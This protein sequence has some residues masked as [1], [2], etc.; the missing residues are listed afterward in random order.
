MIMNQSEER[1]Q[2]GQEGEAVPSRSTGLLLLCVLPSVPLIPWV[3]HSTPR[4]SSS[5][6]SCPWPH[7]NSIQ[8]VLEWPVLWSAAVTLLLIY[9]FLPETVQGVIKSSCFFLFN[10]ILLPSIA[11]L[12]MCS[13]SL[14]D[15][16][17]P[18]PL[19]P[20]I[21]LSSAIFLCHVGT[22]KE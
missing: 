20:S 8:P 1:K 15:K 4:K 10:S 6:K 16:T 5:I 19:D 21:I 3:L 22:I 9:G 13:A 17:T 11:P 18:R 2:E 7:Q 12:W 14:W